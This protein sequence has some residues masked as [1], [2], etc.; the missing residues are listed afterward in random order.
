M[1]S[2]P[3]IGTILDKRYEIIERIADGGMGSVYKAERVKLGRT[4]AIKF[5]HS[6]SAAHKQSRKRFD[7]E[8]RAMAQLDHP[9][10]ATVI[11]FGVS[12]SVPYVVMEYASG[13][14]LR[15]IL[16]R[17]AL[18]VLTAV[19]IIRQVLLGLGH[20]HEQ[21][22]IHRDI[23]PAN[24]MVGQAT[25]VGVRVKLLDFG[26]ARLTRSDTRLTAE[27]KVL[28]TP[29]YM[30]PE[31]TR[32][33]ET[34][35]RSD[36]YACGVL[37]FEMLT[38]KKPFDGED[39]VE[40]LQM[41]RSSAA[42]PMS[43]MI[44]RDFGALEYVVAQALRKEPVQRFQT[45]AQMAS[46]LDLARYENMQRQ[47]RPPAD[48]TARVP[49]TMSTRK[50]AIA[51]SIALVLVIAIVAAVA[52]GNSDEPSAAVAIDA[53]VPIDAA[54]P[55]IDARSELPELTEA[56]ELLKRGRT[57]QA[58]Q[59]LQDIERMHPSEAEVPYLLGNLY[60]NKLWTK[61][62][63]ASYRRAIMLDPDYRMDE[64]L[65][66][67]VMRGFAATN[68]TR[69]DIANFIIKE[70][71][72]PAIPSLTELAKKHKK[73]KVRRRAESLLRRFKSK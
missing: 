31:Q 49:R 29:A 5:L 14:T 21:G 4:V 73:K 34:D 48:F 32:A 15:K 38:G 33:G 24:V 16:D 67:S 62:G 40:I 36:I 22:I 66:I 10:C 70:I 23:K 8:A 39:A 47:Q 53:A 41:Q 63:T 57:E 11:D 72:A 37:L 6:W 7:V 69:S 71:G 64:V 1:E 59:A 35:A 45:A 55:T 28:G 61:N 56:K 54:P 25:G 43:T 58:I 12:N 19:E 20:A 18:G 13:E 46:A 52:S 3:R 65:L 17:G 44:G 26:L 60:F 30:A 68:E 50:L 2:D 9:N 42:P 51:G 27:G